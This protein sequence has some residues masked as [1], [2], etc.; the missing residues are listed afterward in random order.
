QGETI[1]AVLPLPEDE[2]EWG[3]LNVMFATAKGNVRR[4]AMDSFANILSNG[5]FAM[6]FEDGD[7][8]RLIG[9]A[10]LSEGDDVLLASRQ[11]K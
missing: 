8:D 10:L 11:G 9:V 4:N 3:A 6:K 2:A 7:D 1:A 5:K